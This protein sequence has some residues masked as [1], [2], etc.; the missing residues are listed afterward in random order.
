M[1]QLNRALLVAYLVVW[2]LRVLTAASIHGPFY[3]VWDVLEWVLF[4]LIMFRM[5]SKNLY[6]RRGGESEVG[7][8]VVEGE[9]R[10]SWSPGPPCR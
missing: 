3:R 5:F 1:D 9:K 7:E 8:L 2:M 6:R 10:R 4:I